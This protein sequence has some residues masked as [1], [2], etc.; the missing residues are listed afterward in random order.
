M[1]EHVIVRAQAAL[2]LHRVWAVVPGV[3][4]HHPPVVEANRDHKRVVHDPVH[5]ALDFLLPALDQLGPGPAQVPPP[6]E[7]SVEV[8]VIDIMPG[9]CRVSVWVSGGQNVEISRVNYPPEPLVTL[10]IICQVSENKNYVMDIDLEAKSFLL[11]ESDQD[12]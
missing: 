7:A 4:D 1:A 11:N 2:P 12:P 3:V 5:Q 9:V 10:I 6:G 8:L